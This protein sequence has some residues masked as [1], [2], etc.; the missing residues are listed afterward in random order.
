[1]EASFVLLWTILGGVIVATFFIAAMIP[2]YSP[3]ALGDPG[4]ALLFVPLLASFTMGILLV[5]YD[6][7]VAVYASLLM[8]IMATIFVVLFMVSPL[9]V[10]VELSPGFFEQWLS[11]RVMLAV[12]LQFPLVLL[13]T[14]IGRAFGEVV[15]PPRGLGES[16]E[17][18]IRET[19]EWHE[20][21]ERSGRP[22]RE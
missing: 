22:P 12:A 14:V 16:R 10:G 3:I 5:D 6:L 8:T 11:Q 1:M 7:L 17:R 21:L 9:L 20:T 15:I 18:L 19:R 4:L 13:G 2:W